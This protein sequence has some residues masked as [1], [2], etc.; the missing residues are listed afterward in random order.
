MT[1][2]VSFLGVDVSKGYVG[3]VLPSE[4]L[5]QFNPVN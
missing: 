3:Y 5:K 4:D 2:K 1:Q